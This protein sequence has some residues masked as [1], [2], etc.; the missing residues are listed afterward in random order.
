VGRRKIFRFY[1]SPRTADGRY[2]VF[3]S[4]QQ[5]PT[6]KPNFLNIACARGPS[7][8]LS[9]TTPDRAHLSLSLLAPPHRSA[10]SAR[11]SPPLHAPC[12]W[13]RL[14]R[15]DATSSHR[16]APTVVWI[17]PGFSSFKVGGPSSS[18]RSGGGISGTRCM[19]P[20][21]FSTRGNWSYLEFWAVTGDTRY[22]GY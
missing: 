2:A 12:T 11:T 20:Q 21:L 19:V 16:L 18:T 17:T 9:S 5:Q 8:S 6:E 4:A 14:H 7:A 3:E 22:L 13:P 1:V 15:T 10:R